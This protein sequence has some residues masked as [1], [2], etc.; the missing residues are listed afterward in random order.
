[1]QISAPSLIEFRVA[2][3][4]IVL[5][6]GYQLSHGSRVV[7]AKFLGN[8]DYTS[9]MA[10]GTITVSGPAQPA[11]LTAV[12]FGASSVE[13]RWS[14]SADA[15]SYTVFRNGVLLGSTTQALFYAPNAAIG[16]VETYTVTANDGLGRSSPAVAV[17]T[18][19][20]SVFAPGI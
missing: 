2:F 6:D 10:R 8:N 9:S 4:N 11:N 13:L 17:T 7:D 5:T 15:A 3:S 12:P 19:G 16:A 14:A 18:N 1:V 20:L